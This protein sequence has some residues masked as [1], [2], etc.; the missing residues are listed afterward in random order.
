MEPIPP[1]CVVWRAGIRHNYSY[2]VPNP[3][4]LF[5]NY[6]TENERLYY[7]VPSAHRV[8]ND[9][10]RTRLTRCRMI[11]LHPPPRPCMLN[12]R[13]TGRLRKRDNL[14]T[15]EWVEGV[16]EEPN[17]TTA[18][19]AWSSTLEIEQ[20]V[21]QVTCHRRKCKI[22][23]PSNKKQFFQYLYK[24]KCYCR[25]HQTFCRFVG[26]DTNRTVHICIFCFMYSL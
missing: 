8:L 14:L 16:G 11:W 7:A 18:R 9:L 12:R 22:L 17:H 10:W 3:H 6:S 25:K 21:P 1:G 13:H 26:G 20:L 2:C 5:K 24:A 23:L 15:V 4:R 19:K